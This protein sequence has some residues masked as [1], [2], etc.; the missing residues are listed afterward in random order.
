MPRAYAMHLFH[1]IHT[2]IIPATC[3]SLCERACTHTHTRM[4]CMHIRTYVINFSGRSLL[5][6]SDKK[7]AKT[8][9]STQQALSSAYIATTGQPGAM[10]Q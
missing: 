10:A 8:N 1:T 3:E 9:S 4:R 2:G 6:R 5:T 7:R